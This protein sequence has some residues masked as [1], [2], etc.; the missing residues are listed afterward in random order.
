MNNLEIY[1]RKLWWVGLIVLATI[2]AIIVF[3]VTS[4]RNADANLEVTVVP[5]D[6]T[7]VIND[8]RYKPGKIT[9][10]P[11][12]VTI[13]AE[14]E[15]FATLTQKVVVADSLQQVVF[16]LTAQSAEAKAWAKKNQKA[17]SNAETL[18]SIAAQQQSQVLNDKYPLLSKLPYDA[19]FY[20]INYVSEDPKTNTIYIRIDSTSPMGRQVA[21]EQI[22]EWGYE[23]TDYK[24][25]F[26]G[27]ANPLDPSTQEITGE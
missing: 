1:I 10:P 22:R 7:V 9:V 24:I 26:A 27:L 14:R 20:K 21:L 13:K 18:G 3:I 12:E 8:S 19:S 2:V 25:I 11:G 16:A 15:G 17:Y 5:G 6:A 23:P 4:N